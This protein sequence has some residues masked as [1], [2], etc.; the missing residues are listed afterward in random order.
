MLF[1]SRYIFSRSQP[2]FCENKVYVYIKSGTKKN[3][4]LVKTFVFFISLH[5]Y[6]KMER[7]NGEKKNVSCLAVFQISFQPTVSR[8]EAWGEGNPKNQEQRE[9]LIQPAFCMYLN[10]QRN[11]RGTP[12]NRFTYKTLCRCHMK[13]KVQ[14]N[15][16]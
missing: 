8:A 4:L 6:K 16:K 15:C 13:K 14:E 1:P 9:E 11:K 3:S 5:T 7:V 12:K 10:I 2:P